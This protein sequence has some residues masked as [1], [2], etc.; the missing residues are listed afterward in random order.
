MCLY[1]RNGR[2]LTIGRT[3]GMDTSFPFNPFLNPSGL[4]HLISNILKLAQMFEFSPEIIFEL[5]SQ[6]L[7]L[8]NNG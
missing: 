6:R 7:V 2:L 4:G 5:K 8:I 1:R 3:S